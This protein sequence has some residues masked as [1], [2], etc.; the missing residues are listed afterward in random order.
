MIITSKANETIKDLKR[1]RLGKYREET[2]LHLAKG[3]KLVLDLVANGM[4]VDTL[5]VT[6]GYDCPEL[7]ARRRIVVSEQVMAELS[8]MPSPQHLAAAVVTPD[9]RCPEAYPDG[10]VVV[11]ECVQD[12]GNVGTV[13]RSADAL[14]AACV[15][16]SPDSADPFASKTLRASMGSCYNIPV[17]IGDI[18]AEIKKML[19]HGAVCICGDLRGEPELPETADR[20][21]IVI[22]NEGNGV[23]EETAK[24]CRRYRMPILGKA[25][26]LN[27][28][29]F[30]ALMI[31]RLVQRQLGRKP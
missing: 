12:S 18:Q 17:Y 23:T 20:T 22:G 26:S 6:E 29:V 30:S 16:L 5:V 3:D 28:A 14:G 9:T 19:A 4:Q 21:A 25:E 11:L 15:L 8:E 24:L 31:D 1:L 2:G 7:P 13:I 10:L 27:A